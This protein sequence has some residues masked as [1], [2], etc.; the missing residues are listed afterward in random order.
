MVIEVFT[1]TELGVAI[2]GVLG[3]LIGVCKVSQCESISCGLSG[4]KCVKGSQ[5]TVDDVK[6]SE[7]ELN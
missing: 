5:I 4:F 7:I 6:S 1:I 3:A 2:I